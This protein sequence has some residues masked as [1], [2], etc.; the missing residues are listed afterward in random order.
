MIRL[1]LNDNQWPNEGIDH[2]RNVA[3]A[4]LLDENDSVCLLKVYGCDAFGLRDY[5]ETPG[6]GVDEGETFEEALIRELDEEVGVNAEITVF[7]GEITD[8]Y[9]LIKRKNINR[10]YL[11]KIVRKTKIHHESK[12][13]ALIQSVNY[14]PIEK[15]IEKYRAM[16]DSGVSKL[17]KQRELPILLEAKRFLDSRAKKSSDLGDDG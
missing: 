4:I 2:V 11:C 12:G 15:A 6:G 17:V 13:D 3:R 9:N 5:Y 10:Y 16:S 1:H 7:L 8:Y 14:Y